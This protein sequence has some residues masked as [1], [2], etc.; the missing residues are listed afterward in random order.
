MG[1]IASCC[2]RSVDKLGPKAQLDRAGASDG[3]VGVAACDEDRL[4]RAGPSPADADH[5]EPLLA[6]EL[7][8]DPRR[9]SGGLGRY[10]ESR[11]LATTPSRPSSATT[12]DEILGAVEHEAG[13]RS[14]GGTVERQLLEQRAALRVGEGAGRAAVEVEDVED[15][16][17]RRMAAR[18]RAG[19]SAAKPREV[20]AAVL[21]AGT[22]ARRR[23]SPDACRARRRSPPARGNPPSIRGRCAC[24]A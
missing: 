10:R 12:G 20:R 9:A 3:A 1:R 2:S 16:E 24:A 6:A 11:R 5:G 23:A 18:G 21:C 17:H 13:G 14:P 8:L 15:L 7:V 4:D 22:R 19:E